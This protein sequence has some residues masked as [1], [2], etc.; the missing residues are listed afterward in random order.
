MHAV[1]NKIDCRF[2]STNINCLHFAVDVAVCLNKSLS[3][4]IKHYRFMV[5]RASM[6][7]AHPFVRLGLP[8]L[9]AQLGMKIVS[10]MKFTI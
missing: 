9:V 2:H 3:I 6:K 7:R 5:Q 4:C 1:N 10:T 8:E